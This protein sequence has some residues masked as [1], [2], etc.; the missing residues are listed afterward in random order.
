MMFIYR[1]KSFIVFL[2]SFNKTCLNSGVA[3]GFV[4]LASEDD[5]NGTIPNGTW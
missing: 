4:Q 3:T 2:Y 1:G 5:S